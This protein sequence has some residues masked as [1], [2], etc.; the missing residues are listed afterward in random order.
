M[1]NPAILICFA[2]VAAGALAHGTTTRR[3]D[4]F[5]PE[6]GRADR[7]HAHAVQLGDFRSEEIP[8]DLPVKERSIA[9]SRRYESPGRRMTA[10][11]SLISGPPGAVATHTPDVCYP[12]SG[13]KTVR[14]PKREAIELPGGGSAEYYV[15]EFAR[16]RATETD[17]VRV[18]WAWSADGAWVAPDAAR[19]AF[20]RSAELFKVYVVT[21]VADDAPAEDPPAVKQFVAAAFGQYADRFAGR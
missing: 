7:M 4:L 3:W 21:P 8:N 15:A 5:A 9:T 12:S 6:P 13:Y 14:E 16:T 1:K 18:R 19:F 11:I 10:A 2:L 17:R 20:L